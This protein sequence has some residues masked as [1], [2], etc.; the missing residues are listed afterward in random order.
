VHFVHWNSDVYKNPKE[1]MESKN[2][3]GML[4]LA[5]FL[6]VNSIVY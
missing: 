1:A 6:K 3:D 5:V 4:V 2:H